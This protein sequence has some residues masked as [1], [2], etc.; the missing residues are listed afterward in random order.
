MK[1]LF[2][3]LISVVIAQGCV[4]TSDKQSNI[5]LY[6]DMATFIQGQVKK[7]EALNPVVKKK[8]QVGEQQSNLVEQKIEDWSKELKPF[9]ETNINKPIL[10]GAY[11]VKKEH[12]GGVDITTY[13][14]KENSANVQKLVIHEQNE[15]VQFIEIQ[16]QTTNQLYQDIKTLTMYIEKGMVK[17]YGIDGLKQL[18]TGS[19]HQ[20]HII[21]EIS[22]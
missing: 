9:E 1:S 16:T 17:K 3:V 18:A 6:F 13:E 14:S 8:G 4:P 7:L 22:L 11:E 21:G 12:K 20:Y 2:L 15:E 10:Q 5:D 19:P